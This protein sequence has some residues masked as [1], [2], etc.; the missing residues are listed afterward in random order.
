MGESC[1]L[2]QQASGRDD[3]KWSEAGQILQADPRGR[4]PTS[5]VGCGGGEGPSSEGVRPLVGCCH[6]IGKGEYGEKGWGWG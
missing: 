1:H 4:S 2:K 5:D 3:K 6:L